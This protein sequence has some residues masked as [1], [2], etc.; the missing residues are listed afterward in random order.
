VPENSIKLCIKY[1]ATAD[2]EGEENS[3]KLA[4][5]EENNFKRNHKEGVRMAG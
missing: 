3:W 1:Y 4:T 2:E 5:Q